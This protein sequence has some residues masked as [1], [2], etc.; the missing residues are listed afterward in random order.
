MSRD[1]RL[2]AAPEG[3][4]PESTSRTS[5]EC[6]VTSRFLPGFDPDLVG[7]GSGNRRRCAGRRAA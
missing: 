5:A 7:L 4:A 6:E 1:F 3:T 2:L